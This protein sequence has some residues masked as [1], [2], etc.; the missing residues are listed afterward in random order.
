[1][2]PI[3]IDFGSFTLYTYG[4]FLAMGFL[5]AVWF[6]KR[7]A[8]FYDIKPDDVSDLFFVI[9]V[10][11]ILGARLL[12]VLI[13]FEQFESN[14]LDIFKIWNGG[15]VFFGG[16]IAAVAGSVVVL[17]IKKLPFLKTADTIAPGAA[18]GHGIGRLGCFFAGCCYGR[19]CDLPFAVRFTH[20]DSLA[21]L[22]VFLHPTQIY[23]AVANLV[24]F[25]ILIGLQRH[26]RFHGMVF[27]SYI[28]LY[29]V[30]RFIIEF[31]RG[32]FRGDFFFEFLSL[33]QGIGIIAVII[34]VIFMIKLAVSSNA[35]H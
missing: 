24:L 34:A 26:K 31:F 15:L 10:S 23:M 6:S 4:F 19:Q 8:R 1:M 29:S 13:N 25:F 2:H 21:P 14:L 18:L 17:K 27:L 32:D 20:P 5:A 7:N 9:L 16:F 12:Y 11:G 30:F 33:S 28:I 22:H 3:L 35:D